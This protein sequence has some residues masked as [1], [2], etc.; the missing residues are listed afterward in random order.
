MAT[1][2]RLGLVSK[3]VIVRKLQREVLEVIFKGRKLRFQE[4]AERPKRERPEPKRVERSSQ[5]KPERNYPWR[6]SVRGYG[7][8]GWSQAKPETSASE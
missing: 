2:K 6:R 4:L 8:K 3:K 5:Y 7:R 1:E